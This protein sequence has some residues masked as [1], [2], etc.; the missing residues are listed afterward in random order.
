[1]FHFIYP[2]NLQNL[3]F[4]SIFHWNYQWI[5]ANFLSFCL[6]KTS[7]AITNWELHSKDTSKATN[8]L[9]IWRLNSFQASRLGSL[10]LAT[11]IY[12]QLTIFWCLLKYEGFEILTNFVPFLFLQFCEFKAL[13]FWFA[14]HLSRSIFKLQF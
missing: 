2:Q 9:I 8:Y 6:I 1:M 10:S 5:C 11:C 3:R 13:Y 12:L 4:C 14:N 7:N